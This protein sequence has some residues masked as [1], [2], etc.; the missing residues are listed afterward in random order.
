MI[1]FKKNTVN[2]V[3]DA[4]GLVHVVHSIKEE[5]QLARQQKN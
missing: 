4:Q 3:V 1:M 5:R 2:Y